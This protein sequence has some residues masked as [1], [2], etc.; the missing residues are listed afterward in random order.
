M[1]C[2]TPVI[3]LHIS[4]IT[5]VA[6]NMSPNILYRLLSPNDDLKIITA[7]LHEAYAPLANAGMRFLASYQDIAITQERTERGE[8]WVAVDGK[9]IVGIITLADC[10]RTYGSPFYDR[11]DVASFGQFA[12]RT[13]HQ[14]RGIGSTLLKFVEQRAQK[15]GAAE[16]ALDTSEFATHLI[17]LYEKK[18]YRF[19][20][21]V[22]WKST[23]YRSV[24]L[25][26][27][28]PRHTSD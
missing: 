5:L 25:T 9:N 7:M 10:Q 21:H 14:R 27:T 17:S 20:E 3:E 8:T 12:V 28:M 4:I 23:N 15:I 26:K 11:P 6:D 2:S 13:V 16:L 1:L 22:Q 19:V 24:I 18:G